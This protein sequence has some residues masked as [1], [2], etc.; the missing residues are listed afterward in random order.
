MSLSVRIEKEIRPEGRIFLFYFRSLNGIFSI[1]PED[2]QISVLQ[3]LR[4][5]GRILVHAPDIGRQVSVVLNRDA[6]QFGLP[7]LHDIPRAQRVRALRYGRQIPYIF[8]CLCLVSCP[9]CLRQCIHRSTAALH[10]KLPLES[11]SIIAFRR[12]KLFTRML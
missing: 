10:F 12:N 6:F 11:V 3:Y 2:I 9:P 1:L 5:L 4:R 7:P 8:T